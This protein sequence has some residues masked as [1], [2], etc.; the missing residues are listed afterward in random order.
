MSEDTGE[1]TDGESV[2][3]RLD[4][5][6][7]Q[8]DKLGFENIDSRVKTIESEQAELRA[9]LEELVER[10][11]SEGEETPHIDSVEML[12][13]RLGTLETNIATLRDSLEEVVKDGQ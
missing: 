5:V 3:E 8:I 10:I 1:E 11:R 4:T 7:E 2:A 9:D 13:E 6:E 12:Y